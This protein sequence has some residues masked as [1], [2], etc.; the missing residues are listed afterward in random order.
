MSAASDALREF[1]EAFDVDGLERLDRET[2]AQR[3]HELQ[4]EEWKELWAA[5]DGTNDSDFLEAVARELADVVYVAY[6]TADLLGI[7]LDVAL[8]A[9]HRANMAKLPNCRACQIVN[10]DVGLPDP[11]CPACRG[12]GKG[13]PIKREDGKVLKPD[14]WQP[15]DMSEAIR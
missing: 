4:S 8:A 6:G 10:D 7:D 13:K 9:V 15:P 3:R 14:G 5:L 11:L 1:H 2:L 12:T